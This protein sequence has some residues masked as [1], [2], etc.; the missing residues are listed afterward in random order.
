MRSQDKPSLYG[1]TP[2]NSNRTGE[3]LWGKNQF[4][5]AFPL[6]LCLYMRDKGM[7]PIAVIS[8]HGD[9]KPKGAVSQVRQFVVLL[10]AEFLQSRFWAF[11]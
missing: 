7:S 11:F 6:S 3:A 5:S 2:K 1:I 8:T 4:N 9:I 10:G